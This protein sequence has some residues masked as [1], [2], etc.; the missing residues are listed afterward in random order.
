MAGDPVLVLDGI[1]KTYGTTTA[2]GPLD[3][4]VDQGE[5]LALLGPS[6]CG[7]TTTL[8]VIA[9]LLAPT[10]GRLLMAGRDITRLDPPRRDMG[11]VFQNYALFPH[12]TIFA[13]VA[14]GLRMRKVAP[15]RIAERVRGMLDIVGLHGVEE[16]L[17]DQLSGGQRQR[18][19]LAR[20]LVIEPTMLLLDEPLSNLD[21]VLRKRMRY[22]LRE[23]QRRLGITT[24]YVTHDQDEAFEMSDR[25]A[26][27]NGGR[28]EQV[29]LPEDL[30]DRPATRFVAEF[31]GEANLIEGRVVA[32]SGGDAVR[33][34]L[35]SGIDLGA[36]VADSAVRPGDA[37]YLMI[38]PERIELERER[39]NGR[40]AIEARVKRRVFSGEFLIFELEAAGGI[41]M[42]CTKPSLP[43]FRALSSGD[44]VWLVPDECRALP[45]VS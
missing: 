41:G 45:K 27:L 8:H 14:F 34:R 22:E 42:L 36:K 2:V 16:R 1:V 18:V 7:K 11:L 40:D 35:P 3:L 44:A 30:Y 29:G 12:K 28:V 39:P 32:A 5:F 15:P 37:V 24:I 26:L 23:I 9:G 20:A 33:V 19:A 13:N 38:R 31:I 17:P 25:V 10:R 4:T 21:A 6:G 43:H